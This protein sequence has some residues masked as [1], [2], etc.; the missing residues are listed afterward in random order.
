MLHE[1]V[2]AG[3]RAQKRVTISMEADTD[4]ERQLRE[5]AERFG[6][7]HVFRWWDELDDDKKEALS[8]QLKSIDFKRLE[9]LITSLLDEESSSEEEGALEPAPVIRVPQTEEEKRAAKCAKERGEKLLREGKV[10]AFVVAG[11]QA[12]RMGYP[13][14]KGTVPV[15]PV[16]GKS[17]FQLHA[18][19]IL[20]T[21]RRYGGRIPWYIMTSETNDEPTKRFLREHDHF[22]LAADDVRCVVQD[23]LP[24]VDFS[25]K[26]IME[27]KHHIFMSPTGHGAAMWTLYDRGAIDDMQS[28]GIEYIFHFQVDNPLLVIADPVF[29][30]YH[31]LHDAEMSC[32]VVDKAFPRE[33][34]GVACI[35]DGKNVVIEY[36]DL[37][38]ETANERTSDGRLRFWAG[39][40]AQHVYD[41]SFVERMR[42]IVDTMPFHKARKKVPYVNEQGDRV[43]PEK[44]NGIKFESFV[45]DALPYAK[46]V[47]HMEIVREREYTPIK[48]STGPESPAAA[49]QRM[50]NL[51]GEWLESAGIEVPRHDSGDV[52]AAIEI[53][54]LYALDENELA[55]KVDGGLIVGDELY[56]SEKTED[57][58][59]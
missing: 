43:T 30:G 50:S 44:E 47:V 6:Q 25:G 17:L 1:T 51:Y 5:T 20:A 15:G 13:G 52:T 36:S 4:A 12:T 2:V 48:T 7:E 58:G 26:I 45:F 35:R 10:C 9:R 24:A 31:T 21:S 54:P 53:S 3:T 29:I 14:P 40:I 37:D 23:M 41:V 27:R 18:E 42:D 56:L 38:D 16:T 46:N 34:V 33:R 11:G 32:K 8:A 39:S 59:G 28:R 22:G 19:K 57:D 49:K 55:S